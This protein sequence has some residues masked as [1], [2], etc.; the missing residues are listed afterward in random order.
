MSELLLGSGNSRVK[1]VRFAEIPVAFTDV[2]TVDIDPTA[3]PD[4]VHDLNVT[5][6]PF[7]D[8]SFD[9]VCA[10]EVLEHLGQQGDYKAF[11]A[12]FY[13]IWRVL[14]PGGYLIAT[15]PMWDSMWTWGDPGHTRVITRGSLVFL[16]QKEYSQVGE[17][18]MTDYRSVW[19]GDFETMALEEKGDTFAFVL[20]ARK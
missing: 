10:F 4:Y 8:N 11:F 13:E 6:W 3:N 2:T 15:V 20:R 16:N 14:K 17:T 12:H 1:K 18:A 7:A 5:P 19:K 9:E